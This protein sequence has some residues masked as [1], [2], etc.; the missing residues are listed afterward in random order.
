LEN[1]LSGKHDEE[2][3]RCTFFLLAIYLIVQPYVLL[4]RTNHL[5]GGQNSA[6]ARSF[7][8]E[9]F[10]LGMIGIFSLLFLVIVK[11]KRHVSLDTFLNLIIPILLTAIFVSTLMDLFTLLYLE[12]SGLSRETIY[13]Q[14]KG[15]YDY[16]CI[17]T[18]L[19]RPSSGPYILSFIASLIEAHYQAVLGL[20]Y[21]FFMEG[22]R[23]EYRA[24]RR[25]WKIV[26]IVVLY[27]F[28]QFLG[29]HRHHL[30]S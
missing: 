24:L 8:K 12:I 3:R 9:V 17:A 23:L 13:L 16:R 21:V 11:K 6:L 5:S 2:L 27:A 25:A 10:L 15:L 7:T 4:E 18:K 19:S 26:F 1:V 14:C 29:L 22:E 28:I 30:L 20:T